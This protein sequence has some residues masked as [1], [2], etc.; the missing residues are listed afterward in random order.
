MDLPRWNADRP[1]APAEFKDQIKKPAE[2]E[3]K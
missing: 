3:E 2:T 1:D